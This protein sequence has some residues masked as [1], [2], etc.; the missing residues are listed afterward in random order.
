MLVYTYIAFLVWRSY[1]T[2]NTRNVQNSFK[3]M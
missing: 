3:M 2:Q 1:G